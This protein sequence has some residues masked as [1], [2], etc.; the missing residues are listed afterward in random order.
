MEWTPFSA[1]PPLPGATRAPR[2]D[3]GAGNF[4]LLIARGHLRLGFHPK[5]EADGVAPDF[6]PGLGLPKREL[7]IT[8]DMRRDLLYRQ[9]G[10]EAAAGT[11]SLLCWLYKSNIFF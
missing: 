1:E 8:T 2:S 10:T 11:F 3:D 9:G 6:P 4:T 5:R 7:L